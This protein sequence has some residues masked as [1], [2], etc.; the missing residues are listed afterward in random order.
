MNANTGC[1]SIY[2]LCGTGALFLA[3]AVGAARPTAAQYDPSAQFSP[4]IN[5]NGVWSYGYENVPLGSPFALL[6][7][8]LPVPSIPGPTIDSWQTPSFG[9]LGVYDNGTPVPQ[10]VSTASDNAIYDPGMLAMHPG[11]NDQFALVQFTAP[12]LG[13]Y[14]ISGTFEGIDTAWITSSVYLLFNNIPLVS[15]IVTGFGPGF[16]V[17]LSVG[18]ILL[19]PGQT[20]AYAVGGGPFHDTTALIDANVQFAAVSSVP[21]P[22]SFVLL[23]FACIAASAWGWKRRT[24]SG[25]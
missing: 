3:L 21:E 25:S 17:P 14:T 10:L 9:T 19:N 15:G 22:S 16:E 12:T 20:L 13:L 7:L 4:V 18:P 5:P 6:T 8:P 24:R 23:G 2:R 11:P 1:S